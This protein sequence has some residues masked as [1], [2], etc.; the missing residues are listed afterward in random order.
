MVIK[1]HNPQLENIKIEGR[2]G[3]WYVIEIIEQDGTTYY[4]LES[5]QH[6]DEADHIVA[7]WNNGE[8]FLD[9]VNEE[10]SYEIIYEG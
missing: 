7:T 6:G 2:T 5:E 10:K 8:S 3:T 9:E 4:L 1:T